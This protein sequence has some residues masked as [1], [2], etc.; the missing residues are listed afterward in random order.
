[1]NCRF[2]RSSGLQREFY[3]WGHVMTHIKHNPLLFHPAI[4]SELNSRQSPTSTPS[5]SHHNYSSPVHA[6]EHFPNAIHFNSSRCRFCTDGHEN[7]LCRVLPM[8]EPGA[9]LVILLQHKAGKVIFHAGD[10]P[11]GLYS[12]RSG[13]VKIESCNEDGNCHTLGLYGKNSIF[14]YQSLFSSAKLTKSAICL[15]D[16]ELCFFPKVE[17]LNALQMHPSATLA[18]LRMSSSEMDRN[19]KKWVSQVSKSAQQR[20]A[21]AVIF[22]NEQFPEVR[23]TRKEIAQ[24]AGTTPETVI[25]TLALFEKQGYI[26]QTRGRHIEILQK[27]VLDEYSQTRVG[28]LI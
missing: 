17:L 15:T 18:L 9:P 2:N 16:V 5:L 22:L 19:E 11:Q 10:Q 8:Q 20:I 1:W 28:A 13:T 21:E 23:W 25:R 3:P 7:Q 12:V 6:R 24:W 27:E 26:D 14:C 4:E